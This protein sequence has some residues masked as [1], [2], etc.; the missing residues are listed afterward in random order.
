MPSEPAVEGRILSLEGAA[1]AERT[2]ADQTRRVPSRGPRDGD[3]VRAVEDKREGKTVEGLLVLRYVP[4]LEYVQ[5]MVATSLGTWRDVD[6]ATIEVLEPGE[7]HVDR[8][9]PVG[10]QEGWREVTDLDAA[11]AAGLVQTARSKQDST[12]SNAHLHDALLAALRPPIP[13]T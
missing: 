7:P 8:D 13:P 10:H 12:Y 9:D 6:P 3:L 1:N 11:I 4:K 2:T 5:V